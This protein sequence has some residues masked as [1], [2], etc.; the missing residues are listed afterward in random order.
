LRGTDSFGAL[1]TG[2]NG[3]ADNEIKY[4]HGR[5]G[6]KYTIPTGMRQIEVGAAKEPA[7]LRLH[8]L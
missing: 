6:E 3:L 7:V 4:V 2:F 8:R 5:L 1:V